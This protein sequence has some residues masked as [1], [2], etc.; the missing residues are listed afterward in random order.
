LVNRDG[1]VKILDL[2]V[3]RWL[4]PPSSAAASSDSDKSRPGDIV[5][6]VDYMAPEQVTQSQAVDHRADI[7]SLG[8]TFFFLLTGRPPF[9]HGTLSERIAQHQS[10]QTPDPRRFRPDTPDELADI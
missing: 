10:G 9:G 7:Y 2:G 8:C 3:S 6:S 4:G 1:V 5:G